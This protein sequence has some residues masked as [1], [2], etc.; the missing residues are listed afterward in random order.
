MYQA[1][2]VRNWREVADS[3]LR[4][5][6]FI[7]SH[8]RSWNPTYVNYGG[9]FGISL[10][11][12]QEPFDLDA[13]ATW[14]HHRTQPPWRRSLEL[15]RYLV[16]PYGYLVVEVRHVKLSRGQTFIITDGGMNAFLRP[17][18]TGERHRIRLSGP[19]TEQPQMDAHVTGPLC[20]PLDVIGFYRGPSV[21]P[22]DLLLI[23][24]AGA[25]GPTLSPVHFLG[26]PTP[27][28]WITEGGLPRVVRTS[29]SALSYSQFGLNT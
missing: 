24:D 22:G 15:G 21:A 12:T 9:G 4:L 27:S 29:Q 2:Q 5:D 17:I 8:S 20:T 26:H 10:E 28:E 25:Y 16:G 13:F 14:W 18:I 7:H 19:V 1:S 3:I 6:S 11:D 23:D